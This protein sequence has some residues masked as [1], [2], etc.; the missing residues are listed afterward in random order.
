MQKFRSVRLL[1][2]LGLAF[3]SLF[4][5][6]G[7]VEKAPE[8]PYLPGTFE[9]EYCLKTCEQVT[10]RKGDCFRIK[11][12]IGIDPPTVVIEGYLNGIVYGDCEYGPYPDFEFKSML[13]HDIDYYEIMST[14]NAPET[15]Y[16]SGTMKN[17]TSTIAELPW[18]IT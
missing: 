13:F 2:A 5:V 16:I 18:Q 7:C 1:A 17:G 10:L 11:E 8:P 4:A 12:Q 15:Y 14:E 6:N 9:I 3:T